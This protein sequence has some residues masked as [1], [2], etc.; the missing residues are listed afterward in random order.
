VSDKILTDFFVVL[1]RYRSLFPPKNNSP[2]CF[3]YGVTDEVSIKNLT[4]GGGE[5]LKAPTI[6]NTA[7]G[8]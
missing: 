8:G 7:C 6:E 2:D 3:L 1:V 4:V 5:V